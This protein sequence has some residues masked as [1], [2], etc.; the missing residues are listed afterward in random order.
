MI[1]LFIIGSLNLL[2][3]YYFKFNLIHL[4][5]ALI[6]IFLAKKNYHLLLTFVLNI[7]LLSAFEISLDFKRLEDDSYKITNITYLP[8]YSK[9]KIESID[10]FGIQHEFMFKNIKNHHEI[11]D[12]F[13]IETG[14]IK[15]I[16]RPILVKIREQYGKL[17]DPFFN[18]INPYY[19]HFSKAILA[20]NKSEITKYERNLFQKAGLFHILVISG[21]H[22]Y[23]IYT[24]FYH[25]L[26]LITKNEMLKLLIMSAIMLNYLILTGCS[27]SALRAFIMTEVLILY[28]LIYGKINLLSALSISFIT[29]AMILPHTLNSTGFKLSYL[30]VL[31]ISIALFIKDRYNLNGFISSVLA[32]LLIQITTA[33]IVYA[34][35]FNLSPISILSNLI[36]APL[37]LLFLIMK[38]LSLVFYTLNTHLFLLFD[39]INTYI[40]KAIKETAIICSKFPIIQNHNIGIFA[41]LGILTILYIIFKLEKET[42]EKQKYS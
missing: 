10:G 25:L 9:I 38:I 41:I 17:L 32:T 35:N 16:K 39:L 2:I 15:L 18:A 28:R 12:I 30:S 5:L 1:L 7:I 29:N 22:F 33:P 6:L 27:P 37:M 11:G 31:G 40:F 8:K 36:V 34:N 24:I 3:R 26:L 21:L 42:I 14:R 19:S 23:L 20:N 4:N 13:K